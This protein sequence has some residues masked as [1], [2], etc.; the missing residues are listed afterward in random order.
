[1]SPAADITVA[2]AARAIEVIRRVARDEIVPRFRNVVAEHKSDGSVVTEA[3]RAAQ[4]ALE[5]DLTQLDPVPFLAEEMPGSRQSAIWSRGG[6]LWC[7][8]PLDGTGNFAAGVPSFS[9]SVALMEDG[10]SAFGAVY[11]PVADEAFYA[12]RGAGAWHGPRPLVLPAKGPALADAVAEVS[13]RREVAHLKGPLKRHPPCARRITLGSAALAWCHLAAA[14]TDLILHGGQRVWDYAAGALILEEAGGS[15]STF[16][17][18]DF[19][20]APPL[21][22]SVIAARSTALQA[23]WRA[24]I[25][26]QP[27]PDAG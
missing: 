3:D 20:A 17:H 25:R 24:W 26:A 10:R 14:R 13:L 16:T 1:M 5:R 23:A 7:V 12:V 9:V 19:W 22:R 8:D 27:R 4:D 15:A 6:R 21:T 11:D 2:Y 18:D